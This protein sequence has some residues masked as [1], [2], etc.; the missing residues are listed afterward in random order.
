MR[1]YFSNVGGLYRT[2]C[3]FKAICG[4]H[5]P[6][7]TVLHRTHARVQDPSFFATLF[8]SFNHKCFTITQQRWY[9]R[10]TECREPENKATTKTTATVPISNYVKRLYMAKEEAGNR[11]LGRQKENRITTCHTHPP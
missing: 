11:A 2:A 7:L 1:V 8:H 6:S 9:K 5:T 10:K 3:Q 4:A